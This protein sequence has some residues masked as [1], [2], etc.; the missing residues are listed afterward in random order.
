MKILVTN[1]DGI[2]APGLTIMEDIAK[3]LAGADGTVYTV[4]PSLETISR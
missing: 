4:A 3:E 1:D 2:N